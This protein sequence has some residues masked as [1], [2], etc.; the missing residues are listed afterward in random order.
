MVKESKKIDIDKL[1]GGVFLPIRGGGIRSS[2]AIGILKALEE[3]KIPVKGISG[4][5][6]SSIVAALFAC[7]YDADEIFEIFLRYNKDITKGAK[8]YGGKGAVAIEEI[9]NK[10]TNSVLMGNLSRKCW[11][12]ASQGSILKPKLYL[13]SNDDTPD[14]T[15]GFACSASAGLP[16]FYGYAY[17]YIDGK[18]IKLFDGG[19]LYNPY[20]PADINYPIFYASFRN[21]INYQRVI[22]FLQKPV[23]AVN[24][25]ADVVVN[26]P[27]GKYVV[28]GSNEVIR[29]LVEAGYQETKKVLC[30]K[31]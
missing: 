7:G 29:E 5:S 24:A 18:R 8:I 1:R 21:T 26:A 23:D 6:G 16:V 4:E 2:S 22:P 9:V 28:T 14:E 15:L 3:F 13:F 19:S 20:I 11:I 27:V 30:R 17:K 10:A 12:N 31:P 25:I